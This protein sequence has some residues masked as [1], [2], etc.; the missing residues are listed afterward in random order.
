MD[1]QCKA[2]GITLQEDEL[3]YCAQCNNEPIKVFLTRNFV[4]SINKKMAEAEQPTF[5]VYNDD[6]EFSAWIELLI[7]ENIGV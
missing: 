3:H 5:D 7:L 1:K 4:D 6:Y 2:C